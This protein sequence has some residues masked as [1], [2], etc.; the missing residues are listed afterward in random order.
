MADPDSRPPRSPLTESAARFRK[1]DP[2]LSVTIDVGDSGPTSRTWVAVP[3]GSYAIVK[4]QFSPALVTDEPS[5]M[6]PLSPSARSSMPKLEANPSTLSPA[7]EAV[8]A[9]MVAVHV[10][11]VVQL[12]EYCYTGWYRGYVFPAGLPTMAPKL[13]IFPANILHLRTEPACAKIPAS[14][15]SF[16][17]SS[18]PEITLTAASDSSSAGAGMTS[19]ARA[20]PS[21]SGAAGSAAVPGTA[22]PSTSSQ[23]T[24]DAPF[25]PLRPKQSSPSRSP[26]HNQII[27]AD[28]V[29]NFDSPESPNESMDNL[30]SD[31]SKILD[32]PDYQSPDK[33]WLNRTDGKPLESIMCL[34]DPEYPPLDTVAGSV[35]PIIDEASHA[36]R[37]WSANMRTFLQAQNYTNY[38]FAKKHAMVLFK[39]R[40]QLLA[41]MSPEALAR[42]RKDLIHKI[43][44]GNGAQNLNQILHDE[45]TGAIVTSKSMSIMKIK[46]QHAQLERQIK[47]DERRA[48]NLSYSAK[49]SV[50]AD[51]IGHH[52]YLDIKSTFPDVAHP[53]DRVEYRFA[54]YSK[55]D[56]KYL[57]DDFVL[58]VDNTTFPY[59]I[60][61]GT[62]TVFV[63]F[64]TVDINKEIVLVCRVV[65]TSKMKENDPTKYRR[66]VAAGILE[67][68]DVLSGK[69]TQPTGGY[70]L[71]LYTALTEQTFTSLPQELMS[72]SGAYEPLKSD[73]LMLNVRSFTDT[74]RVT[75]SSVP[76]SS[77]IGFGDPMN[78]TFVRNSLYITLDS[79][80]FQKVHGK[81]FE[82]MLQARNAA[83]ETIPGS[84][85]RGTGLGKC[86]YH[87]T[88]VYYHVLNPKWGETIRVDLPPKVME[89]AHVYLAVRPTSSSSTL[90]SLSGP[91]EKEDRTVAFGWFPLV[92]P[93]GAVVA[94]GAQTLTLYKYDRKNQWVYLSEAD[95]NRLVPVKDTITVSTQLVSTQLTQS[96]PLMK[97][98]RWQKAIESN[99]NDLPS[100]LKDMK[101]I[102][103][104]ET[105]KFVVWVVD[106]LL[107]IMCSPKNANHELSRLVFDQLLHLLGLV[108][109]ER[110]R[111]YIH[112]RSALLEYVEHEFA[113]TRVAPHLMYA[114][115]CLIDEVRKNPKNAE[116][117]RQL[118]KTFKVFVHLFRFIIQ[119]GV[120]LQRKS[121]MRTSSNASASYKPPTANGGA[122]ARPVH[123]LGRGEQTEPKPPSPAN[124][125]PTGTEQVDSV[126][127]EMD[128]KKQLSKFLDCINQL[129]SDSGEH[130]SS[131][132]QFA[133]QNF[134]QVLPLLPKFFTNAEI[135]QIVI[136]F[137]NSLHSKRG[138]IVHKKLTF[139]LSIMRGDLF[140][141]DPDARH[142]LA[143]AIVGWL[144]MHIGWWEPGSGD[145]SLRT[146]IYNECVDILGELLTRLQ[147]LSDPAH[148]ESQTVLRLAELLPN[149][150]EAYRDAM[151][152]PVDGRSAHN[153]QLESS[154]SVSG[155]S[156]FQ[157]AQIQSSA[158]IR[159][160]SPS[161]SPQLVGV[162]VGLTAAIPNP[163]AKAADTPTDPE[164]ARIASTF[165]AVFSLMSETKMAE[166]FVAVYDQRGHEGTIKFLTQLFGVMGSILRGEA[167]SL[168]WANL[169]LTAH[170]IALKVFR[171]IALLMQHYFMPPA[172]PT[173]PQELWRCYFFNVLT[174]LNSPHLQKELWTAQKWR[175]AY[176]LQVPSL[177]TQGG[178]LMKVLWSAIGTTSTGVRVV[179]YQLRMIPALIPL[180]LELTMSPHTPLCQAAS[181]L[182]LSMMK[183]EFSFCRSIKRLE[184]LS[185]D[186]LDQ[187]ILARMHGGDRHRHI[188][189]FTMCR[190]LVTRT[191][192]PHLRALTVEFLHNMDRFLVLLLALRDLPPGTEYE[193]EHWNGIYKLA[194]FMKAIGRTDIY[195]KYVHHLAIKQLNSNNFVEAG[196]TLKL[197]ADLLQWSDRLLDPI[198]ELGFDTAQKEFERKEELL[199]QIIIYFEEGKAW[200]SAIAVGKELLG[201]YDEFMYNYEKQ[202]ELLLRLSK[203]YLAILKQ[204][205][206]Y[207]EYFR[208]GYY[209]KGFPASLRNK[210]FIYRGLEWEKIGPF[211]ERI[212]SKHPDSVLLK[213]N[214]A[215]KPEILQAEERYLQITAVQ[216]EPDRS[217]KVFQ[218]G[219]R[220]PDAIRSY[221]QFNNV[222]RFSVSRPFR[223]NAT[224]SANEF[225]DLWTEKVT[226]TTEDTFPHLLRRSEVVEVTTNEYSPIENAVQTMTAKNRE[227]ITLEK[228]YETF[229]EPQTNC[230]PLTMSINGAVDAPVNGG[231]LMYKKAFIQSEFRNEHPAMAQFVQRLEEAIDEQVV[232]LDRC[233]AIHARVAPLQMRPLHDTIVAFFKKNFA[234]EIERLGIVVPGDAPPSS[235]SPA[236]SISAGGG[237][238]APGTSSTTPSPTG[239][240]STANGAASPSSPSGSVNNSAPG[241]NSVSGNG[242]G[243]GTGGGLNN[244]A[245]RAVGPRE[246]LQSVRSASLTNMAGVSGTS[247]NTPSLLMATAIAGSA[248]SLNST[249]SATGLATTASGGSA[250]ASGVS[251]QRSRTVRT[252]PTASTSAISGGDGSDAVSPTSEAAMQA[253]HLEPNGA[254]S[255]SGSA[256]GWRRAGALLGKVQRAVGGTSVSDGKAASKSTYSLQP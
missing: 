217:Q 86:D 38:A 179:E 168:N 32:D 120:I 15:S 48:N 43:A 29:M 199:H 134:A 153:S 8:I 246:R 3:A 198:P 70:L 118:H 256:S 124:G 142:T 214:A 33:L 200:E 27:V 103:E 64:S 108:Y 125:M 176:K 57:T 7:R 77:R 83:G 98:F 139:I 234:E 255:G 156:A 204:E 183:R 65:R 53:G 205:R 99:Y 218:K 201:F 31:A 69:E 223:K 212:Q 181:Y 34:P 131:T 170:R 102:G 248:A 129:M 52:I 225:L 178:Q 194:K 35:E 151:S 117:A 11:D 58:Q 96:V 133:F 80:E 158:S 237:S 17:E 166:Y 185:A 121:L 250:A 95:V 221:Y 174:M 220:V 144:R 197:H 136:T 193:D 213:S 93:N 132:Q 215:P 222:N 161:T 145:V 149:L 44:L 91:T 22:T 19:S 114:I 18:S 202:S 56:Q 23:L 9:A 71:K 89:S 236:A 163:L 224:K 105:V 13:G 172:A 84:I 122:V 30:A 74:E 206:Y 138:S 107:G 243:S 203:L 67:L 76:V 119:C 254:L 146:Q 238:G 111:R 249:S 14:T 173:F 188:F 116:A 252:R 1:S 87:E 175:C 219:D 235:T 101:F 169:N 216:P 245:T 45:A 5:S 82:V 2:G 59:T 88:V 50:D 66:P 159:T 253:L 12:L 20:S 240:P 90:S 152:A 177:L 232:I 192:V 6:S 113:Y 25:S 60:T 115:T 106:A 143:Q 187:L 128:Y 26:S 191:V 137:T 135:V 231:V 51:I 210:Q 62:K 94:D 244:T 227:L 241:A 75:Y 110:D 207:S 155:L 157:S 41:P 24:L 47:S 148:E 92:R 180:V 72:R 184:S 164:T 37:D 189:V 211:C 239:G 186:H 126:V 165:V 242:S 208:V 54:I 104:Q 97:V 160:T 61:P 141:S 233:I 171:A 63:D 150:L 190:L 162:G 73:C 46:D 228:K 147:S 226:Y 123:S 68:R 39:A 109:H 49:L 140:N 10:G 81:S 196:W 78:A 79:G 16:F 247:A 55:S 28:K 40:R 127:E 230:N 251:V 182:L 21:P 4:G 85:I 112:F 100:L 42:H 229:M 167:Y 154:S 195:L 36:L 130:L 209:G